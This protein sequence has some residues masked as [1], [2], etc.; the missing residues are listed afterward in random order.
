MMTPMLLRIFKLVLVLARRVV[1]L[2]LVLLWKI[3]I[4]VMLLVKL[5]FL[6]SLWGNLSSLTLHASLILSFVSYFM[7]MKLSASVGYGPT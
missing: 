7:F 5:M 3:S 1:D 6:A 2:M 4:V